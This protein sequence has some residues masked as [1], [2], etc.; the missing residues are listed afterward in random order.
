MS[1]QLRLPPQ[2]QRRRVLGSAAPSG[3]WWGAGGDW[4]RSLLVSIQ[5]D[6]KIRK[7]VGYRKIFTKT[8]WL[9]KDTKTF[10]VL[11]DR[12][13]MTSRRHF[14]ELSSFASHT[15]MLWIP[16]PSKSY[17][18]GTRTMMKLWIPGT[19]PPI[20]RCIAVSRRGG[21]QLLLQFKRVKVKTR[22]PA[23]LT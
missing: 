18:L 4:S 17:I 14:C 5:R 23:I 16:L 6:P 11:L 22:K 10:W 13:L 2:P 15:P 3:R 21:S 12:K 1:L 20:V 19:E 7:H 9:P 8:F